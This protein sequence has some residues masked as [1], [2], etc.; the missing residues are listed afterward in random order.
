MLISREGRQYRETVVAKFRGNP[1]P[2]FAGPIELY[3][4]FY[5]PDGRRRDLDNLLKCT[6][7]TL[8]H[9]G[10]YADD[11]QISRIHII[12]RNPMPPEGL[13]YIRIQ[14][15]HDEAEK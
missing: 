1:Q 4:E 14:N 9:A 7:D 6:Q 12:K 3:A 2:P 15:Y 10:L 8:Q 13:V 11:S 5:P